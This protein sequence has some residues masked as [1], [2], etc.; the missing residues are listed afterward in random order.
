V[1]QARFTIDRM[2]Q[3]VE[4]TVNVQPRQQAAPIGHL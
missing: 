2:D 4:V 3:Y 1:R